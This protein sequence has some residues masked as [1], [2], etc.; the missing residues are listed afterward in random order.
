VLFGSTL[1]SS[2]LRAAW[3]SYVLTQREQCCLQLRGALTWQVFDICL[4]LNIGAAD[5]SLRATISTHTRT[6]AAVSQTTHKVQCL[7][8]VLDAT[9]D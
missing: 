9:V 7:L 8:C 1:R 4:S 6:A 3:L 5:G 2:N